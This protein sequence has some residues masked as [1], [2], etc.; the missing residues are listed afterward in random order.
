MGVLA[1]RRA[2]WLS[3]QV[4]FEGRNDT[5]TGMAGSYWGLLGSN[6]HESVGLGVSRYQMVEN[7]QVE[8]LEEEGPASLTV[9]ELFC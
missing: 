2:Y 6:R 1:V 3:L 8:L 4:P 9:V 7:V 5:V